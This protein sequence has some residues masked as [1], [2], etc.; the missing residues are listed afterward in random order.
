MRAPRTLTIG[1]RAS[2]LS[3]TQAQLVGNA[4][5]AHDPRL[6]IR[7]AFSNA[8]GDRDLGASLPALLRAGAFTS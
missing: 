1:A 8:V 7:Y 6:D 4:L 5:S 2:A 3:R